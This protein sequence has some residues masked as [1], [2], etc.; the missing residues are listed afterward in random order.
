MGTSISRINAKGTIF[1]AVA[2]NDENSLPT[3][4]AVTWLGKQAVLFLI[5]RRTGRT[6]DGFGT[7]VKDAAS[8]EVKGA[9]KEELENKAKEVLDQ[10]NKVINQLEAEEVPVE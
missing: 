2:G 5:E 4:R 3:L 9:L 10:L 8:D 6:K 1:D 7:Y